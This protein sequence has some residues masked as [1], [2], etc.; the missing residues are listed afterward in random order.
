MVWAF[1]GRPVESFLALA[2]VAAG[3]LLFWGV[4]RRENH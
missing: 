1:R 3:G 2:T 4:N